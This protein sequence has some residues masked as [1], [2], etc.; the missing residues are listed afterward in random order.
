MQSKDIPDRPILELLASLPGNQWAMRYRDASP[1][2]I[3]AF[4]A[5]VNDKLVLAKMRALVR[6]G[7]V[8]GCVCGCRGDFTI[9]QKG[10]DFLASAEGGQFRPA[11]LAASK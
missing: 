5:E 4:P 1:S 8:D 7:L 10:R 9:T 3:P 2:I 6:R 11:R